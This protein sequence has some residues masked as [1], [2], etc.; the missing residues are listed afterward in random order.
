MTSAPDKLLAGAE[1]THTELCGD[2]SVLVQY[3]RADPSQSHKVSSGLFCGPLFY[4]SPAPIYS[5]TALMRPHTGDQSQ[6]LGFSNAACDTALSKAWSGF[7]LRK[8]DHNA[9][10]GSFQCLEQDL[11]V[12]AKKLAELFGVTQCTADSF[13]NNDSVSKKRKKK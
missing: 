9:L 10:V 4:P 2:C 1:H 12:H 6:N 7:F 5:H 11:A 13:S 8:A 3:P